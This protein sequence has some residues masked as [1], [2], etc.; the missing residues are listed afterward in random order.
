MCLFSCKAQQVYPL[1]NSTY[2]IPNGSYIKDT[3]NDLDFY[4]GTWLTTYQGRTFRLSIEKELHRQKEGLVKNWY[5]DVLIVRYEV[6]DLNN[7]LES[8]LSYN[9]GTS[10]KLIIMSNGL[11]QSN[12]LNLIYRGTECGIGMGMLL[13][14]KNGANQFLWSYESGTVVVSDQTCP[15]YHNIQVY[16]PET[17]NLIFTKQ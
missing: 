5:E 16:L 14:K 10:K 4:I 12:D 6:K 9:F 8:T 3:N 2:N 13:F 17:E 11:T 7:I 1:T 15:N